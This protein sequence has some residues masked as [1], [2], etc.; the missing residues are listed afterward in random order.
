MWVNYSVI[1]DLIGNPEKNE[2]R[3]FYVWILGSSPRMTKFCYEHFNR[4]LG[5]SRTRDC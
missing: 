2:T 3:A 1:P 4:W 5:S